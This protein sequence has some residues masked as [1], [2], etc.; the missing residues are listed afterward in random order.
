M[1]RRSRGRR[2]E[3]EAEALPPPPLR[4]KTGLLLIP[5]LLLGSGSLLISF[6]ISRDKRLL[7]ESLEKEREGGR[8]GESIEIDRDR[9]RL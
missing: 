9:E 6:R 7:R 2:M 5:S 1:R 8:E 3:E 4:G